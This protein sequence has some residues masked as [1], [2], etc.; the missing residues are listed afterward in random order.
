MIKTGVSMKKIGAIIKGFMTHSKSI[1]EEL[2]ED[3]V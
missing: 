3:L 1:E 2:R